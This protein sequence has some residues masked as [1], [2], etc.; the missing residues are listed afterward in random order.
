M[1]WYA[2]VYH[3]ISHVSSSQPAV[4]SPTCKH[5]PRHEN[6]DAKVQSWWVVSAQGV[7]PMGM[8]I[9]VARCLSCQTS[10]Y[11]APKGRS[12]TQP[13]SSMTE[14]GV[15]YRWQCSQSERSRISQVCSGGVEPE[16]TIRTDGRM[17][18]LLQVPGLDFPI[19]W[20]SYSAL[21]EQVPFRQLNT[22]RH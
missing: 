11:L 9:V 20:I 3:D 2:A 6:Q 16:R 13:P 12:K 4:A 19:R 14:K 10:R 15:H 5:S 7:E 22:A 18:R 17:T 21:R 1:P 8:P